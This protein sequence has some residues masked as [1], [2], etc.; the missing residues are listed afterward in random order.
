MK[1]G[2]SNARAKRILIVTIPYGY[3][4]TVIIRN[5]DDDD[6]NDDDEDDES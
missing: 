4:M 2:C 1:K 5:D 6:S 3:L